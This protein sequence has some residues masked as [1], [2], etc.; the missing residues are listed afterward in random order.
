[1]SQR[2]PT[3]IKGLCSNHSESHSRHLNANFQLNV[4]QRDQ[5][6][7]LAQ[8]AVRFNGDTYSSAS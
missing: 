1:M 6:P 2:H 8:E 3:T 7:L 5:S 4:H